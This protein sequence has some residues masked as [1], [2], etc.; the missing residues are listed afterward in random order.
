MRSGVSCFYAVPYA[1]PPVGDLRFAAPRSASPWKDVLDATR[2]GP[3]APQSPSRLMHVMGDKPREQSEDCLTLTVWTPGAD[4]RRRPV[5]VWFHG[6]GFSTGGGD[7]PWY[8]GARMAKAGDVVVVGVNY[9]L[10]ALGFLMLDGL[11]PGNLGLMDQELAG[12]WVLDNIAAFG[13]DPANVTLMGQSAGGLSIALLLGRREL[14]TVRRAILMS[15][16]LGAPLFDRERASLI[17]KAYVRALGVDPERSDMPELVRQAPLSALM[18]AQ[19]AAG[20]YFMQKLSAPGEASP[21]FMPVADGVFCPAP[22]RVVASFA[23]TAG[24]Y[25]VLIGTTR[26]EG[27]AFSPSHT[28]LFTQTFFEKPSVVW[29]LKA[30][31]AGRMAFLYRFDWAPVDSPLAATHCIELPFAFDTADAFEGAGMLAGA[32][33]AETQAMSATV[34]SIW[35]AYAHSGVPGRADLPT[36]PACSPERAHRFHFDRQHWSSSWAM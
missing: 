33:P 5:I 10:G 27:T 2:P 28:E 30:A 12:R 35:T 34:R 20:A 23:E 8:D 18:Q 13:G 3:M 22:D 4:E 6:G 31:A 7:L 14:R 17:A 36:W 24:R 25:D 9:R 29:A 19:G 11:S 1:Q 15:A 16:P 21:P 32:L 26:D